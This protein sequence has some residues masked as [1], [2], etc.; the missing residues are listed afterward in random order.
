MSHRVKLKGVKK[1]RGKTKKKKKRGAV[2][3]ANTGES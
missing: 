2:S 3:K 1:N